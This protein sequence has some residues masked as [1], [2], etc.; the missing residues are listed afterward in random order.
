MQ[1]S[2]YLFGASLFYACERKYTLAK[3]PVEP[4]FRG[5]AELLPEFL[6]K[7]MSGQSRQ[8]HQFGDISF[9]LQKVI[10]HKGTEISDRTHKW[11]EELQ[12]FASFVE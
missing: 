4:L 6:L 3:L 9:R 12:Q 8:F 1:I 2:G 7:D 5:N 11:S 10:F